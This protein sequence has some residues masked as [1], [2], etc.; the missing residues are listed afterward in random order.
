MHTVKFHT[1]GCKVNQYETQQMRERVLGRG[2]REI[3]SGKKA[4]IYIINTCTVT[5][6]ADAQSLALLRRAKREN[7]RAKIIVTGCLTELDQDKIRKINKDC[8]IVKNRDKGNMP[9]FLNRRAITGISHFAAHTRAF[10]KIQDGCNNFCSYCKVPLVRGGSRS[11]PLNDIIK[12]AGKLAENGFKEIVLT[13]ICLGSYGRD[14][15]PQ[16]NM[17]KV[18]EALEKINGLLR[19][20]LSSIEPRDITGQLIEKI[21]LSDKLCR[22][23]HIPLQ[24]GD[25]IILK[26]M[27][28]KYT[29]E[30]YL[31]LIRRIK[32]RIPGIAIST[33]LLVGFPG[34]DDVCFQHTKELIKKI[35]PLKVHI[36][37]YSARKGTAAANFNRQLASAV[38]KRRALELRAVAA[39]CSL[40]YRR[41]FLNRVM[42]V[43]VEGRAKEGQGLWEGYTDN[44]IKV[45]FRSGSDLRNQLVTLSLRKVTKEY[46]IAVRQEILRLL[47]QPQ[48]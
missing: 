15:S 9:G 4:D 16:Q 48:D 47:A 8:L 3:N 23:L 29:K 46:I 33:D 17:I 5:H 37:S 30:G 2:F 31:T 12:E 19:I 44:Y 13:G 34:E 1:L 18:I 27:N 14:L 20:R 39:D 7:P 22:H 25:D 42:A 21:A 11:K 32:E 24:S 10:L 36:F 41:Q 45:L 26:K 28:R 6:K 43:L 40:S 38:I 35:M